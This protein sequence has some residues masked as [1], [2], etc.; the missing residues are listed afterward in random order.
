MVTYKYIH[1]LVAPAS[2]SILGFFLFRQPRNGV[3][4]GPTPET[5]YRWYAVALRGKQISVQGRLEL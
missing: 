1:Q 5:I 3:Y 2:P 4:L